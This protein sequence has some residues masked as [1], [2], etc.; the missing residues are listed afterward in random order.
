M[1]LSTALLALLAVGQDRTGTSPPLLAQ[2]F[3][4]KGNVEWS[5]AESIVGLPKNGIFQSSSCSEKICI[6]AGLSAARGDSGWTFNPLLAQTL[7]DGRTWTVVPLGEISGNQRFNSAS[8][9]NRLCIAVGGVDFESALLV[10]SKNQGKSWG[11]VT[12]PEIPKNEA[13][14]A[15]SCSGDFCVAV[16]GD[17]RNYNSSGSPLIV[18]GTDA[19]KTWKVIQISGSPVKGSFQSV[20]CSKKICVA[21]GQDVTLASGSQPPLLAQSSDKGKTWSV[22]HIADLL[23]QDGFFQSVSCSN[24]VCVAAGAVGMYAAPLIVQSTDG[25]QNWSRIQNLPTSGFLTGVSCSGR[26]CVASGGTG[27]HFDEPLIVQSTDGGNNW[28]VAKIENYPTD[29]NV[30][31]NNASC[32]KNTCIV[33]GGNPY[34]GGTEPPVV[35]Q[36]TDGGATWQMASIKNLPEDGVFY[37]AAQR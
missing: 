26:L 7:N 1:I 10:Q 16:G 12:V 36:T 20:S 22:I 6:V 27:D 9:S 24:E 5:V 13:F 17:G 2:G 28:A 14:N 31:F 25:G 23:P 34:S 11:V 3:I 30:R 37:A 4:N 21:G 35:A 8:C 33:V 19:G 29:I 18:R 15:S 32:L